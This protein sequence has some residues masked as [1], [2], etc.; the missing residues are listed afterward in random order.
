MSW[1]ACKSFK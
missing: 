1:M